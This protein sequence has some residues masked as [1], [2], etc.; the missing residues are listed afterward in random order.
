[1]VTGLLITLAFI[2]NN[3]A[4]SM[5]VNIVTFGFMCCKNLAS[6]PG[7]SSILACCRLGEVHG[8]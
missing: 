6:S 4:S 7:C 1:M 3:H 5:D 2:Q 8:S